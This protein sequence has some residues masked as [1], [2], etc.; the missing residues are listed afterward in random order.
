MQGKRVDPLSGVLP[1]DKPAGLTSA[2][3]IN[4]LKRVLPRGVRVGHAG[5][6]DRFATGVLVVLVGSA[7]RQCERWM[8]AGKEYRATIRLGAT[9]A[10]LDPESPEQAT[11]GAT[12]PDRATLHAT[13][14]RFVGIIQQ[15]PP[16]FSAVKLAGRRASDC[17]RAGETVEPAPRRVR[18]VVIELLRYDWPTLELRIECGRGFYVRSLARD[19]GQALGVGAYLAAPRRTRVGPLT[20][21][22]ARSLE[23]L[24]SIERLAACLRPGF[25]M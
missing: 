5:T 11:S 8:D 18:V 22:E 6:L 9:T 2:S 1:L 21:N 3:A 19:L 12:A 16:A 20:I 14:A 17:V 13:L 7:T 25:Q 24:D 4:R 10:T 23:S 15:S